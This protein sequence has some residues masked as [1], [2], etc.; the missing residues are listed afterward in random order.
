MWGPEPPQDT[1]LATVKRVDR[2]RGGW[3]AVVGVVVV[4]FVVEVGTHRKA[5][6]NPSYNPNTKLLS[7]KASCLL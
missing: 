2:E 6:Y 1:T 7:K 3:W 4:F 5:K